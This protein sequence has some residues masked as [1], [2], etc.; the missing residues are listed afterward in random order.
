MVSI[1]NAI[2]IL[3]IIT[4]VKFNKFFPKQTN[5]KIIYTI[6]IFLLLIEFIKNR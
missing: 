1:Y 6:I 5:H 2:N 4:C 3:N